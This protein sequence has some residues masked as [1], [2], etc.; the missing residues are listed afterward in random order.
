MHFVV[1]RLKR[2]DT[3]M[4]CKY[5]SM[6]CNVNVETYRKINSNFLYIFY[7]SSTLKND[8]SLSRMI[9][10]R[11]N[12]DI[13]VQMSRKCNFFYN[14]KVINKKHKK[15]KHS[16]KVECILSKWLPTLEFSKMARSGSDG[17][18]FVCSPLNQGATRK[19]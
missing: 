6:T 15:N 7:L 10:I 5:N 17:F 13:S 16:M 4:L 2:L 3:S 9:S 11:Y 12:C 8:V 19:R 1:A 14:E 18:L